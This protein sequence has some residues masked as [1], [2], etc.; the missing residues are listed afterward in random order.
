MSGRRPGRQQEDPMGWNVLFRKD[1]WE[2]CLCSSV[3]VGTQ[4]CFHSV[5][6]LG[7]EAYIMVL[8]PELRI[9]HPLQVVYQADMPLDHA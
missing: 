8:Q 4:R 5:S 2:S 6:M 7:A 1:F 9:G 3:C